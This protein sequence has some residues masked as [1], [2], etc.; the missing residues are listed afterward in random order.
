V[1]EW[2]GID[3][4]GFYYPVDPVDDRY[5]PPIGPDNPL[6]PFAPG[7]DNPPNPFGFGPNPYYMS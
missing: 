6:Q 7:M 3:A 1:R 5:N 4:P 2:F